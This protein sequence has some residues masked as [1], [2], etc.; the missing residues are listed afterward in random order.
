MTRAVF[1]L[2]FYKQNKFGVF[3]LHENTRFAG[4]VYSLMTTGNLVKHAFLRTRDMPLTTDSNQVFLPGGG[5][6]FKNNLY[7]SDWLLHQRGTIR[8]RSGKGAIR[9]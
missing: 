6:N 9:K 7:I 2:D 4:Y 8:Q 1:F 3:S 5:T